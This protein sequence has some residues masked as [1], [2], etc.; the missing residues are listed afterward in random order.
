L[1]KRRIRKKRREKRREEEKTLGKKNV[2][3]DSEINLR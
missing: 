2:A 1:E 3:A